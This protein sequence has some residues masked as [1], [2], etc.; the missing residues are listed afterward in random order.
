MQISKSFDYTPAQKSAINTTG[1]NLLVSAAAGSGKT[2][3][4][5]ERIIKLITNPKKPLDIDKVLVVT[6]TDAAATEMR[7]RI[8]NAIY[9]RLNELTAPAADQISENKILYEHLR[10]QSLLLNKAQI[11]TLHSFCLN[12]I[13]TNF[14]AIGVDPFFKT[15]DKAESDLLKIQA[16]DNILNR[17]YVKPDEDG[18]F[19]KLY[20]AFSEKGDAETLR[21]TI[22]KLYE[23]LSSTYWHDEWIEKH[24]NEFNLSDTDTLNNTP[25]ALIIKDEVRIALNGA[26]STCNELLNIAR[27]EAFGYDEALEDDI[28]QLEVILETVE[29]EYSTF[30]DI[31]NAAKSYKP[32]TLKA[33][34]GIKVKDSKAHEH[35]K[36][37]RTK[38]VKDA[39][40]KLITNFFMK[41]GSL[42]IND[43]KAAYEIIDELCRVTKEFTSEYNELKKDKALLDFNDLELNCIKC[44]LDQNSTSQNI[45]LSQA[46]LNLREKFAEV[47]VDEYQDINELQEL[48]LQCVSNNNC[49]M[50]GD[51]KQSI[52]RFRQAK[53]ELFS[54]KYKSY[55]YEEG[56]PN[57]KIDLSGNFRSS[58]FV[59]NSVNFL[60]KQLLTEQYGGTDYSEKEELTG[61]NTNV[62]LSLEEENASA[63]EILIIDSSD[64]IAQS[65]EHFDDI[66]EAEINDDLTSNSNGFDEDSSDLK[67]AEIE[68]IAVANYIQE[69]VNG[70]SPLQVFDKKIDGLRNIKYGD[71]A[72]LTRSVKSVS[73]YFDEAFKKAGIP[74]YVGAKGG[75]LD[76]FEVKVVLSFLQIIDNPLQDI[77]V[78]AV[79]YSP[80][81][82]V[83][84]DEMVQLCGLGVLDEPSEFDNHGFYNKII[85]YISGEPN[86]NNPLYEKL[87]KFI[88]DL[89]RWQELA[90]TTPIS[91]LL[92]TVLTETGYLNYVGV[93]LKGKERQMNL[94]A[95]KEYAFKYEKSSYKGIFNFVKYI[96]RLK[97]AKSDDADISLLSEGD[98]VVRILTIHKSKGLE[99]PVVFVCRTGSKFNRKDE[100]E[101]ILFN[102]SL[103]FGLRYLTVKDD[104]KYRID[105]IS[106]TALKCK[107]RLD[108]T[109]EQLRNLYVA[110]TRAKEKLI[111]TGT[112]KDVEKSKSKW[113]RYSTRKE[114]KLPMHFIAQT[115]N[116]LDLIMTSV[117][118]SDYLAFDTKFD[119]SYLS[120]DEV[121]TASNASKIVDQSED[122]IQIKNSAD[123]KILSEINSKFDWAYPYKSDCA[124]RAKVSVSEAKRIYQSLT[125]TTDAEPL[126]KRSLAPILP[127]FITGKKPVT[128]SERG[129]A[130]HTVMEHIDLDKHRGISD[131]KELIIELISKQILSEKLALS[132]PVEKIYNFANSKLAE[133]MRNSSS[134]KREVSFIMDVV[135]HT[136]YGEEHLESEQA[137]IVQGV[138]DCYF[139][140][141]GEII[142]VDYKSDKG[143]EGEIAARYKMQMELYKEG[144]ERGT[145]KKVKECLLYLFEGEKV[146]CS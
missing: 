123:K 70:N 103:G 106:R 81:Y 28:E 47:M 133:R 46:A 94:L 90:L 10:K 134:V 135:P 122:L 34:K 146:V 101:P 54:S 99:F 37:I 67:S 140:E 15:A 9:E 31:V 83:T 26:I 87:E 115:D 23:F 65:Y 5:V 20:Q 112:V 104:I 32:A 132:I 80:V 95:L 18:K 17:E 120:K 14:F 100:S 44:L 16:L 124:I 49:F 61:G 85:V 4:L 25:W 62:N 119:V 144:I 131:I 84:A 128:G 105:T 33:A 111:F 102:S 79:L 42:L 74:L 58:A 145:G 98:N 72:I 55:L 130:I 51:L 75:Y 89:H 1:C 82:S 66:E 110:A 137:V 69:M 138:I 13:R 12:V 127:D 7:L 136:I 116:F 114:I 22:L 118:R 2:A 43:I 29:S 109:S 30:D 19:A 139:E 77:A 142:I 56:S 6:F 64:K 141:D 45:I 113:E 86:K 125:E 96:E 117:K 71:I 39:I 11:S 126:F 73:D 121:L 38:S 129:M 50:V 78:T 57:Q 91:Q 8:S 3:V 97:R 53:P 24:K 68:A 21:E 60:F 52:Y 63:V 41:S 108:D 107:A 88:S 92:D 93:M 36:D 76:S 48:I 143:S 40:K 59:L 35:V 27:S